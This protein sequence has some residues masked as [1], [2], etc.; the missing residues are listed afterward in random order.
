MIHLTGYLIKDE[1]A[2]GSNS[3]VF[4]GVRESDN[5]P[6]VIKLLAKDYPSPKEIT[7][8]MHEFQVMEKTFCDGI[9][10]PYEIVKGSR[11]AIIMEDIG[12]D[13][14]A[15]ALKYSQVTLDEKLLLSI[16]MTHSLSQL[17]KHN[18]I[19]KDINPTNFIWNHKTGEV[20]LIDF[21]I[22]TEVARESPQFVNVNF[23][24]GTPAYISPEQTGRINRPIDCRTDLYSLG[25]SFYEMFTGAVP[26]QGVDKSELIYYHIAKTPLPPHEVNPEVPIFLSQIIMK[27]ISKTAEERYQTAMGLKR[28]LEFCHKNFDSLK[29]NRISFVPGQGDV[30][31]RF[32]IPH[33][34]YG[35]EREIEELIGCF[36]NASEGGSEF[37]LVSG[38]SGVGKSSLI[39]EIYK[40]ITAKKGYYISGKFSQFMQSTPYYGIAQAFNGLIKQLHAESQISLDSLKQELLDSLG[41]YGQLIVDVIPELSNII[42]PQPPVP[43]LNPLEFQNRFK[44]AFREFFMV[45][46]RQEHPLVIFLDDL[47]WSDSSTLDL[48]EYL[49]ESGAIKY[50]FVIGA[51]RDNEAE[52]LQPLL[53]KLEKL[54]SEQGQ[55]AKIKQIY[56]NPLEF[57]AINQLVAETLHC[58]LEESKPLSMIIQK[59]TNGNPFFISQ[60]LNTLFLR[61]AIKFLPE[62]GRW[63]YDPEKVEAAEISDNVID[64]LVKSLKSLP[65][66]TKRLLE[67]GSCIG[68]QFDLE[69]ILLI[70]NLPLEALAKDLWAAI[71]KE[72]IL[73][74]DNNYRYIGSLLNETD[75][76]NLEIRF[77]FAHDRI[78]QAVYS[79]IPE[80]EKS[81]KHLIIGRQLLKSLRETRRSDITFD[82]VNHL[83][84]GRT[85]ITDKSDRLELAELNIIAGLKAMKSTAFSTALAY[86]D[87]ASSALS[88]EEWADT[89]EKLFRLSL[90]RTKAA[91]LSGDLQK[92]EALIDY[93]SEIANGSLEKCSVSSIRVLLYIFQGKLFETIGEARKALLLLGI[94]LPV[95]AKEIDKKIQS[96]IKKVQRFLKKTPVEEIVNLPVMTDPEKIMAMQLLFQV[97]PQAIQVNPPLFNLSTLIMFDLTITYGTTPLSCKCLGDFGVFLGTAL[98]DYKTGYKL[99]EA[100]FSLINKFK[101]EAQKP[102]VYFVFSFISPF[103]KHFQESLDYYYMSYQ[104]G[105]ETGDLMHA[106]FA[107]A[108]RAHLSIWVGKNLNECKEET[109][110]SLV[111]IKKVNG[112]APQLLS[113]IV[114][115]TIQKLQTIPV[116]GMNQDFEARDKE[117]ISVIENVHNVVFLCRFYQFNTLVS[118]I[119]GDIEEAERWSN[120][121]DEVLY[122]VSSDFPI[123]DH[124]L[125]KGLILVGKWKGSSPEQRGQIEEAL[126]EIKNRLRNLTDTCPENFAHKYYLLT[127]EIAIIQNKPLE[128]IVELFRKAGD[129]IGGSDFIQFKALINELSGKF[130]LERGDATVSQAYMRE[131][132][133]LYGKWGADRK[134]ALMDRDISLCGSWSSKTSE[135]STLSTVVNNIDMNS[136]FKAT[137]AISSEIKIERLLA[138]L[139]GILIE[140][141]GAQLGCILLKNEFD[142]KLHIEAF[143]DIELGHCQVVQSLPAESEKLC[144]EIVQ[145]V[146][147]TKDVLVIH[148]ASLD[149]DWQGNQYIKNNRI[150]SVLCIPVSYQNRLKGIVYLENNLSD[151]VFTSSRMETIK[152]LA[153]QAAISLENARLYENMEGKVRERTFQLNIANEKLRE[154]S[155][156]DSL[157]GLYNRRYLYSVVSDKVS[158]HLQKH[159]E[160]R[161]DGSRRFS[162]A[163]NSIG[164]FLID[165]DYFK[166]VND[167][168][169]HAAGDDVLIAISNALGQLLNG[170]D[171]LV[172]W[173]GEEF[174]IV[175]FNG[176]HEKYRR[177]ARRA[178]ETIENTPITISGDKVIYKTCSIGYSE[179]PLNAEIPDLIDLEQSIKICDYA[180]YCAKE[181]GRNCSA[182]FKMLKNIG[183]DLG[184]INQLHNL[185]KSNEFNKEYFEIEYN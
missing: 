29:P 132:Y 13:S 125:L 40:P 5:T 31:D 161:S 185:S 99:G 170:D 169:G 180:L 74:L 75:L 168:Y 44:L 78:R 92:A 103:I 111:F 39:H 88:A 57:P 178:A 152:I 6:V 166:D 83:N 86:F 158:Q 126:Y 116:S 117:I 36:E 145:Y 148:D 3:I 53:R 143:Q 102:P 160:T 122:A 62:K 65:K 63:T 80:S 2:K 33:K 82:L 9:I 15:S 14:V 24:E 128:T 100:A 119:L 23:L 81:R 20:K 89:K 52:A 182:H 113:E 149:P 105:L 163:E 133:Y 1:I 28:D 167:T 108:N 34:L 181:K 18:I 159:T 76:S 147:R 64:L 173:G 179:I 151:N 35:R 55:I 156:R 72:I 135:D 95:S 56:L 171:I 48:I 157:T 176:N 154:L 120:M 60:M 22:S 146:V 174:L 144:L 172:R 51:Y 46:A 25:I 17:H 165:I 11:H 8:F 32:E 123:S 140:N 77:C 155:Q 21:G 37:L 68:N 47:Q 153:S 58:R 91:V 142:G 70:S 138:I 90:E 30:N 79:V 38:N 67:L 101:A 106:T 177:F 141:T 16:K 50:V 134:L 7:D 130:W 175:L 96:G 87:T 131:A 129:Y 98:S 12:G 121:A 27:L 183:A 54:K 97:N 42:G 139:I 73:P 43:D 93:L 41:S 124:Y 4:R 162:S 49:L 127:A 85:L 137:Q 10:K 61:K 109:E 115:Y 45:F 66:G 104:T 94:N 19:H 59:K 136:I 69:T 26:F 164:A 71:E 107:L 114:L 150:R 118:Y 112:P 84:K 110:N 184:L